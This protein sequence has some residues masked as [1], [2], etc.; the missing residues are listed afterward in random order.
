M[1]LT[2]HKFTEPKNF[3][4][5]SDK[6]DDRRALLQKQS[7]RRAEMIEGLI[8]AGDY[9]AITE[10]IAEWKA[11]DEAA[12]SILNTYRQTLNLIQLKRGCRRGS[13]RGGTNGT[14]G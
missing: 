10:W 1:N 9:E 13:P 7:T 2:E 11:E 8:F 14:N 3:I 5:L 4:F 6:A 12:D